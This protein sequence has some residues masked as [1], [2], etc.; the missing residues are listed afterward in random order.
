[1]TEHPAPGT[2]SHPA[3]STQHQA[4]EKDSPMTTVYVQ[5]L[6]V[7]AGILA[8]LWFLGRMFS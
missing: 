5:V 4:P 2:P 7:E 6:V 3:P 1:M 8:A